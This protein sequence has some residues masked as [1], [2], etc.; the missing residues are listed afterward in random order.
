MCSPS[1]STGL[2]K[3]FSSAKALSERME[4]E[5]VKADELTLKRLALLYKEAGETV[6]FEEPTVIFINISY[7]LNIHL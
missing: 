7:V 4:A 5:G 1:L 6:P 3:D 2:D